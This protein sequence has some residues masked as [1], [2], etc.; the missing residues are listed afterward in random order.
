MAINKT[1]ELHN[2]DFTVGIRSQ[3][4]N[5]NFDLLRRWIEAE[6]LR[7][8]GWGLV[9]GFELTKDLSDFSIHVSEGT[10]IIQD[11]KEVKVDKY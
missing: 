5:E 3:Q 11:G 7:V 1:E 8:G 6:R 10:L 9:E 4:I 2:L